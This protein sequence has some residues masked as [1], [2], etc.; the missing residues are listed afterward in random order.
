MD[1]VQG[2]QDMPFGL[3]GG[4]VALGNFDGVHLGHQ[5]VIREAIDRARGMGAPA[6]VATFDPHPSRYF[7]PDAEPFALTTLDQKLG[8]FAE[9]GADGAVVVPFNRD[10]AAQ[11]PAEFVDN[12]IVGRL[13][14]RHVVTGADF[15]FG[16]KRSGNAAGLAALG[17]TRGFTATALPPV[18]LDGEPVSS[19]RIRH[20]LTRGDIAMATRLLS[21]PFRISGTVIHGNK[22][23]RTLGT[24]TANVTLDGYLRPRFGV[25]AVEVR[26][27]DGEIRPGV[28]NLGI[29]PMIEPPVEL[30]E[31][32]IFDWSGDLYGKTIETALIAHIRDEMRFDSFEALKERI[33]RD[34]EEARAILA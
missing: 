9:L 1:V 28:A 16:H 5:A 14:A 18:A 15:T 2:L 31:V 25:Y 17:E 27:P 13:A 29:R 19:T 32:W 34:A 30:L 4:A 7:H 11:S 33:L 24:P 3:R 23:G 10:L 22:L 8:L 26:L 12:W 20:A 21:R 6:V